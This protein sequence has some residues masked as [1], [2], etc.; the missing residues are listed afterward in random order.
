MAHIHFRKLRKWSWQVFSEIKQ[1]WLLAC[2]SGT[3]NP[4]YGIWTPI[5]GFLYGRFC[6]TDVFGCSMWIMNYEAHQCSSQY[7][8]DLL[9]VIWPC[10]M[11]LISENGFKFICFY[12]VRTAKKSRKDDGV[13]VLARMISTGY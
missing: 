9:L 5:G 1:C 6:P 12:M 11:S 13:L 4:L 7:H 2:I 3:K 10:H 8:K